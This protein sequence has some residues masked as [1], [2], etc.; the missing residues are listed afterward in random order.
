MNKKEIKNIIYIALGCFIMSIGINLFLTPAGVFSA[1]LFGFAQEL[2][3]ICQ[4]YLGTSD[5]TSLIYFSL[6]IPV[7]LLGWYKVGH[8]FTIRTFYAIFLISIFTAFIPK[9]LVLVP[10]ILLSTITAGLFV[11]LGIGITLRFGGSTGGTD[12]IALYFS[13]VKGKSFGLLNLIVNGVVIILAMLI[14]HDI[15]V[16]IYM[17]IILYVAG[18]VI[19]KVHNEH[20]KLSLFIITKN[21]LEIREALLDNLERGMT[22]FETVGGYSQEKSNTIM[23][24]I[25]KDEFYHV[26]EIVREID[27]EAFINVYKID[28][29]LGNFDDRYREIL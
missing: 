23:L 7:I 12:I 8:K 22:T 1:G 2:S 29:L 3:Y 20:E 10:D 13:L 5:I 26:V 6:N 4:Q 18:V 19:D 17:V 21:E 24:A 27:P 25:S 15:T 14:L 9:D 28:R 11:G 16:G